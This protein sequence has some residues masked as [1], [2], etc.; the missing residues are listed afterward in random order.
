MHRLVRRGIPCVV[1]SMSS[2]ALHSLL[3]QHIMPSRRSWLYVYQRATQTRFSLVSISR[4]DHATKLFVFGVSKGSVSE[5]SLATITGSVHSHFPQMASSCSL[6]QTINRCAFGT[7]PQ[8]AASRYSSVM[9]ISPRQWLGVVRM[10]IR[11]H[12]LTTRRSSQ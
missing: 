11:H 1:M 7:W 4:R 9:P 6:F 8:P 3:Y 5:Y 12:R 10:S 2:N